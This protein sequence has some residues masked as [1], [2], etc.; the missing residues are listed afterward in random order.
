ME[1]LLQICKQGKK[2]HLALNLKWGLVFFFSKDKRMGRWEGA[3][4]NFT[5]KTK[6]TKKPW[7][8]LLQPGDQSLPKSCY[9]CLFLICHGNDI[10]PLWP[11]P[12]N[13]YCQTNYHRNIIKQSLVK[14]YSIKS[15]TSI[16]PNCESSKAMRDA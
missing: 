2:N 11:L 9:W 14:E 15:L 13:P 10:L 7:E 4:S 3:G 16:L 1:L 6:Q 8:T 12:P 5:V